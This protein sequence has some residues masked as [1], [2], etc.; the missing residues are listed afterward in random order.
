MHLKQRK[1]NSNLLEY[2]DVPYF[3]LQPHPM[4]FTLVILPYILKTTWFMNIILWNYESVWPNMWPQNKYR[5][6]WPIFHGPVILAYILKTVCVW[7][8]YFGIMS[9]YDTMFD[10]KISEVTVTYISWSS[11]FALYVEDYLMYEHHT[12]WLWVH[13][14]HLISK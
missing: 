2:E 7:T 12:L 10:L 5:S 6:L 11:D 9:K 4:A 8:S 3:G 13:M 1:M 14:T